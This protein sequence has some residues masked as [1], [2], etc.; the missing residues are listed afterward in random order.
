V[1]YGGDFEPPL[2]LSARGGVVYKWAPWLVT[3]VI[4]GRAFQA[5]SAVL[6]YAQP[7]FGVA[8]NLIGNLTL[9]TA[10]PPL[11]PQT[12]SGVEAVAYALMGDVAA[13]E[14]AAFYQ[15]LNDKIEFV[16]AGTDHV[17]R[18]SGRSSYAGLES[19]LRLSFWRLSPHLAASLLRPLSGPD[20]MTPTLSSYP[21]RSA[22]L[23]LDAE[24]LLAP[25]LHLSALVRYVGPRGATAQ[26]ILQNFTN[27][28]ELPAFISTDV[29]LSTG[30][31]SLLGEVPKTRFLLSVRNP[32]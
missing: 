29:H 5:P 20:S 28:Y 26:N 27:P 16:T 2:Q 11:K 21:E 14:L 6:M 17:A 13:F 18:N 1:S 9:G 15:R 7:G 3:K 31:L 32:F 19:S 23:G 4:A 12:L 24:V 25:R 8:N 22:S 10:V 30:R